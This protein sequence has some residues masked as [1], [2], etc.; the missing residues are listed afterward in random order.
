MIASVRGT[1]GAGP[2]ALR[3]AGVSRRFGG[4]TAVSQVTLDVAPGARHGIIGPNGA[5]KTTL[6]NV[7]SG[8]LGASEGRI[9]L[10]GK[11][12]TK[13]SPRHR[14]EMGLGRTYQITR[15]F[16]TLTVRENLTL[17]VNG[18][19]KAKFSMLRSW[20]SYQAQ[21]DDVQELA[22]RFDLKDRLNNLA[23]DLSH[24]ELRQL[25]V[26]LAIALKP[27]LLLLD[28]PGAGLS[29]GERVGMR[30]LLKG[31]PQDLTLV[32]IEHD[33]ELVRDVVE[34]IHVL[35]FG[36]VVA[37]GKTASIQSDE[38]VREIYLGSGG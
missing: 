38:R 7:I 16:G 13:L 23:S 19:K 24:G 4:V 37:A 20:K 10:F 21:A 26:A 29:P 5:G 31:L 33:M 11:D 14:V 22:E 8:E 36:K 32:M 17:A 6:F 9:D 1:D 35:H 30:A 25:E 15:T 12:I 28:E 27:S 3:L 18:L 34:S 2:A